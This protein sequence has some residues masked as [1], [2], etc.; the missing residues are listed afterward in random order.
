MKS[1]ESV[2]ILLLI[3]IIN[4]VLGLVTVPEHT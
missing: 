2:I 3:I 4:I 1:I